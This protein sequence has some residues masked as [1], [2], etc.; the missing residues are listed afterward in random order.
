MFIHH[1]RLRDRLGQSVVSLVMLCDERP[2]RQ[3]SSYSF[4]LWGAM[5]DFRFPVV[6]LLD[7]ASQ[8]A[9]LEAN[10][11]LFATVV[12]AHLAAQ[13]TRQSDERR[14]IAKRELTR[15]LYERSYSR[16]AIHDLSAVIDWLLPLPSELEA[17]MRQQIAQLESAQQGSSTP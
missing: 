14:A 11:N 9:M 15:Q 6:T 16:Q 17:Q 12:L 10:T 2:E 5:V 4:T 7:Y 8:R 1:H 3:P 13:E